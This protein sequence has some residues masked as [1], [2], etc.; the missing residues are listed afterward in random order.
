MWGPAGFEDDAFQMTLHLNVS[1]QTAAHQLF[2]NGSILQNGPS[3]WTINFPNY[4]TTS[5]F[6]VHLS[7]HV[8]SSNQFTIHG[9]EKEIPVTVYSENEDLVSEA[10]GRLPALFAELEKDYGPFAHS[11]FVAYIQGS[12]GGM[13][14]V[15]ATI[16]STSALDHELFHS[17]F[18]RGVMPAEGRSGWIDE[19]L[20]SWRDYGY[21]QAGSLLDRAPTNLANFSP[22][23]ISTP[24]NCYRDGRNMIAELDRFLA[25]FGGMKPLLRSFFERYKYRVV[26][27]EEFQTFL[28]LKTEKDV[29]PFFQRYA[30][31]NST[32][33]N[34]ETGFDIKED[35]SSRHP[36][37][38]SR[39]EV[40]KLR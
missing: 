15:G 38:L 12:G 21:F 39:E 25:Q 18:A 9:I 35:Q 23:R 4:F 11:Q 30:F 17:W 10:S 5:S 1:N 20:A 37:P 24:S 28:A 40:L 33:T 32:T 19:G 27:T 8:L 7:N 16:T 34:Q 29:S 2:T 6:Y 14:Y 22:F 3:Q 31:G 36:R 26:T 13:E